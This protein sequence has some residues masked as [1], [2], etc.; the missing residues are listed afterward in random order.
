MNK[1]PFIQIIINWCMLGL[2]KYGEWEWA[3]T[4]NHEEGYADFTEHTM[5]W[6]CGKLKDRFVER[7]PIEELR[8]RQAKDLEDLSKMEW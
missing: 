3:L 1:K 6:K 2:H 5:C 4:Y 8:K 7:I